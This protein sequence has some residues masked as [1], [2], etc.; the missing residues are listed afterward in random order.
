MVQNITN[1]PTMLPSDPVT[2][3]IYTSNYLQ[4]SAYSGTLQITNTEP[5]NLLRSNI[6]LETSSVTIGGKATLA[7]GY[8]A[9][10]EYQVR[11]T[12]TNPIPRLAW[13]VIELPNDVSIAN[14]NDKTQFE[15]Y[16]QAQTSNTFTGPDYCKLNI[17]SGQRKVIV[18]QNI[19]QE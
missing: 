17:L 9:V 11:F 1:S 8:G 16:C 19:F 10:N 14:N 12:P 4:V 3:S 18:F 6:N 13:V 2:A 5:G 15:K 7:K